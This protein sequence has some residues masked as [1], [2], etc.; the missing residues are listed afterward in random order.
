MSQR[1]RDGRARPVECLVVAY[2]GLTG[3]VTRITTSRQPDRLLQALEG[4]GAQI[5]GLWSLRH[6][7]AGLAK[8]GLRLGADAIDLGILGP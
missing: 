4:Q 8:Y 5:L 3:P 1:N 2:L 7:K 6:S